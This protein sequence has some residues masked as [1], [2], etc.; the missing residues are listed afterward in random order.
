MEYITLTRDGIYGKRGDRIQ[1]TT[2][3]A[4]RMVNNGFAERPKA[5]RGTRKALENK[6]LSATG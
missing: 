4:K 5:K 1:V 3:E 6:S 2:E